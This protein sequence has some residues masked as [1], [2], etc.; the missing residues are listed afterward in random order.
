MSHRVSR[1]HGAVGCVV[2]A[3]VACGGAA[4]AP[5]PAP[6]PAVAPQWGLVIH[7]GAGAI[8]AELA[9]AEVQAQYRAAL[10][11]ALVA[12]H[13]VLAAGG[14]STD[15]V[16]AVVTRLEDSPLFNAGKGAVFTHDGAHELD[17]AIMNGRTMAAGAVAG[18]R[19]VKN[20]ILAA[21]RVMERS[22]HVMLVG[23]GADAFAEHEGLALVDP[24]YF[25]TDLRRRAL[26][27]ALEAEK[28]APS[29]ATPARS[30]EK[31][32]TVGAVAL[33]QAGVL[34]A[35][36]ST[37]GMTNKRWGRV[38][39]S[40]IIGAGTYAT[41]DCAVSATGHGEYFIRHGVAHDICARLRY[42]G[43]SIGAAADAVVK[44]VLV[45][46]GGEGG[47]IAMDGAGTVAMPFN[48]ASMYRGV[49]GPDGVPKVAVFGEAPSPVP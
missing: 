12:G 19:R 40:P 44:D 9:G 46:A 5:A 26:D 31:Y 41:A 16:V 24:S 32:G 27:R 48:S 1:R 2:F 13:A 25:D 21:R 6:A 11:D 30:A 43:A 36:T 8:P 34:A 17:A 39:D 47:V 14:T 28:R 22:P 20:P 38:G 29:S 37:G 33:D 15:A 45:R 10:A 3:L 4:P 42:Q 23:A 7:G 35:A 18:V 49:I